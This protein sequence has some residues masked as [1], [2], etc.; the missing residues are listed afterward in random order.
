MKALFSAIVVVAALTAGPAHATPDRCAVRNLPQRWISIEAATEKAELLGYSV[1][2]AKRSNGCW[3]IEGYDRHGAEVEIYFDGE[4]GDVITPNRWRNECLPHLPDERRTKFVLCSGKPGSLR[5][6]QVQQ[7]RLQIPERRCVRFTVLDPC[8]HY[9][10]VV[11]MDR[12]CEAKH[13][14]GDRLRHYF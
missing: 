5:R 9:V 11:A 2:E 7:T 8:A 13:D 14:A 10:G 12:R 1:K 4:S 3:K 6:R